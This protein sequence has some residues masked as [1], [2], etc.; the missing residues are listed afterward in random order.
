MIPEVALAGSPRDRGRAHGETFRDLIAETIDAWFE[1]L[2]Q[3][4]DPL[5]FV[6][7]ILHVSGFREAAEAHTP[8]YMDEVWGISEGAA[9]SMEAM[10]AWQLIDECWWYLDEMT[11]DL[12]PHEAC[13]AM[14][15]NDG[16]RGIAAQT[17]DL[18]R[19]FD[20]SQVMLRY[21][22]DDGLEI[23]APSAA[24]LLAYNGVN[25]A[26]LA[27]CITTL[28]QLAHQT[29][30][31]SSGF[32]VPKLL[33]CQSVDEALDWL[34]SVPLASGNSWTL[35]TRDRSVVVEV[36]AEGVTIVD[37]GDRALHTNHTLAQDSV[38][39]YVR[40]GNSAQRLQQLEDSVSP[41]MTVDEVAAMYAT[42]AIC[43]SRTGPA[44]V[45]SVVTAIFEMD[46]TTQRCHVAPGPLDTETLTTYEMSR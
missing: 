17:Q 18:Y 23:L 22:D 9:Q 46:E 5:D 13:S 19:H 37:D 41:R 32:I 6:A 28:S 21:V 16:T 35:G 39:E 27:V 8:E 36:S 30:G 38:W 7:E 2:G 31:V 45:M 43:Q 20:G 29:S 40:F 42:G 12:Q 15:I 33:R 44:E 1:V 4:T 25:S 34:R 11:G 14:A 3:R 24:G 10:F 26:G